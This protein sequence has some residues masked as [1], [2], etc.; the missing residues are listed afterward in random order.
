MPAPPP[1]DYQ[2]FEQSLRQGGLR[3]ALAFLNQRTPHRY[4]GIFRYDGEMLRN[5]ALHDKWNVDVARGSD[6]PLAGAYCSVVHDTAG[7][8]V[9]ED[10]A[11]DIRFPHLQGSPVLSYCG[12]LIRDE[13]G[14]KYGALCH[15]DV[16]PCQ[17]KA[18]D[19]PLMVAATSPL[20]GALRGRQ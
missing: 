19:L 17:A 7:P 13:Q 8:L 5:V 15:Y 3:A 10:G 14:N 20:Y 2:A 9:V 4:T 16:Q 18:S 1:A 11:I 12:A 6:L